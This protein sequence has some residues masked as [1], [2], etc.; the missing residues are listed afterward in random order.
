[1]LQSQVSLYS[2]NI[3]IVK[4]LMD[5]SL[6]EEPSS[7]S[8]IDLGPLSNS[9]KVDNAIFRYAEGLP[10]VLAGVNL[11]FP[12]SSYTGKILLTMF[13]FSASTT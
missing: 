2:G 11:D 7:K 12:K 5:H 3:Q 10:N 9:L 13:L 1:M 8:P 4:E 6:D